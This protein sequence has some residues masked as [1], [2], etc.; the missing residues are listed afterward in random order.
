MRTA[1]DFEIQKNFG[2]FMELA[3]REPITVTTDDRDSV[4]CYRRPL[5]IIC[6]AQSRANTSA[7]HSRPRRD[8]A[9]LTKAADPYPTSADA[10]AVDTPLSAPPQ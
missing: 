5:T 10:V 4:V 2:M 3:Q 8:S 6:A 9:V 7:D 1:T